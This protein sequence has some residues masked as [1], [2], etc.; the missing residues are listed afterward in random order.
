MGLDRSLAN[1]NLKNFAPRVG[2]ALD[3]F[4]NQKTVMR[5][6]YGIYYNAA[7]LNSVASQ[8]QSP[9][10]FKR[11]SA[12]NF[13]NLPASI[14]TILSNPLLGLP[15]FQSYDIN[16]RTPYFQQWNF[17]LQQLLTP[18]LLVEAQ[19]LGSKGTHLFTSIWYNT[20]DPWPSNTPSVAERSPF[21]N[22]A[23]FA[24]QAGAASS[25]YHAL[26]LRTEK[27]LSSGLMVMSSYTFSKSIDNDSLGNTVVSSN[28]DQSNNKSLERGLSSF[29]ARH[30][31]VA[32][33]T[34]DLP[35]KSGN[36]AL[37]ALFG[38]WQTG[39]IITQQSGQPFTVNINGD[40]ANNGL[41]LFGYGRPNLVGNPN[42]PGDQRTPE[43]WFNT[44]AFVAQ[45]TG[46]LGTAGRNIL[47][48]P[49]TN[50]VDFSLLKNIPLGDRHR[51]QFRT[52]FFNLFNHPNFDFPERIC[53]VIIADTPCSANAP[54]GSI[55]AARD[56]RI[57]QF[58]LKYLF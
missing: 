35:F 25:N 36:K 21:P 20:P 18:N 23:N 3:L 28:L 41:G 26:V 33:F 9:P 44:S 8:S 46:S 30:R 14:E 58:A 31:F 6:G 7:A 40:R 53:T 39:G 1:K 5:T 19:Y 11:I 4:G 49:G 10:F 42:L 47:E 24:L 45:P 27:R 37:F 48:G 55:T 51:L 29:D 17:G 50:L 57:L 16:F 32:S 13:S 52:E 15:A 54:F 12:S 43:R 2:L 22:L 38:N 56:P 34:Y